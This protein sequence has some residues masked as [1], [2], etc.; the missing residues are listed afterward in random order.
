MI[1]K[2][3]AKELK[4]LEGKINGKLGVI[5]KE[6]ETTPKLVS[7]A[8]NIGVE[9]EVVRSKELNE[10]IVKALE[11]ECKWLYTTFEGKLP[12]LYDIMDA[13]GIR[14]YL[15]D[16]TG[17]LIVILNL[18]DVALEFIEEGL[19]V[20][21]CNED[22]LDESIISGLIADADVVINIDKY[23]GSG[24]I[25]LDKKDCDMLRRLGFLKNMGV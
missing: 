10:G 9:V 3:F 20:A 16:L 13:R 5:I 17:K 6:G 24:A 4:K 11:K 8:R 12:R 19:N 14:D 7:N 1:E 15:G 18:K 23:K 2:Y 21:F 25:I 22:Q